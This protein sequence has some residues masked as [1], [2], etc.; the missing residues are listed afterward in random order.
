MAQIKKPINIKK[1]LTTINWTRL[2]G[3]NSV[4]VW[5]FFVLSLFP[6]NWV[7]GVG[8]VSRES[9]H[10]LHVTFVSTEL[11]KKPSCM[12]LKSIVNVGPVV[13]VGFASTWPSFKI[14]LLTKICVVQKS[15]LSDLDVSS[16]IVKCSVGQ[17]LVSNSAHVVQFT[18]SSEILSYLV[19]DTCAHFFGELLSH[20]SLNYYKCSIADIS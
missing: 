2:A 12:Y 7:I 18:M 19:S 11:I 4:W 14:R 10:K 3:I 5:L 17:C 9:K 16:I 15:R 1:R 6:Q 20:I 8:H 13:F